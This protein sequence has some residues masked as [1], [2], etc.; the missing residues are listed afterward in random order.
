MTN[1][2]GG[3]AFP[4]QDTYLDGSPKELYF[5][6]T[7]RDYFAAAALPAVIDLCKHDTL[8]DGETRVQRFA[9][10]AYIVADAMIQARKQ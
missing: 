4:V 10:G 9:K 1:D 7:L 8:D 2:T 5:G 6:M 3:P